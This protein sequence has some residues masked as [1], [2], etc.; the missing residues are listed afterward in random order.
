LTQEGDPKVFLGLNFEVVPESQQKALSQEYQVTVE[1][2]LELNF[3]F[4]NSLQTHSDTQVSD[5]SN[6]LDKK[7]IEMEGKLN[8][9]KLKNQ[10]SSQESSSSSCPK[11]SKEQNIVLQSISSRESNSSF[12]S[13]TTSYSLIGNQLI[14]PKIH[15]SSFGDYS[16]TSYRLN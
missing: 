5:Y 10:H 7:L 2:M 6:R 1:R 12:T 13:G 14:K 3:G 9:L 16:T 11:K 4:R 15:K 8:K